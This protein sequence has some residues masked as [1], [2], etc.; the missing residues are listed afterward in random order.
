IWQAHLA[1]ERDRRAER[2]AARVPAYEKLAKD[3]CGVLM[4]A[5]QSVATAFVG[6]AA[7][8]LVLAEPLRAL[9]DGA[10]F[11]ITSYSLRNPAAATV[12]ELELT[13]DR[14]P[15]YQQVR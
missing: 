7:A 2:V 8:C 12:V 6:T 11:E 5:G 4:L 14:L 1:S 15:R 3:R 10:C 9:H 13:A